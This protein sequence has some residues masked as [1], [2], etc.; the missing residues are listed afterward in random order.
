[1][2]PGLTIRKL[3][4]FRLHPQSATWGIVEYPG[5]FLERFQLHYPG[6]DRVDFPWNA[7]ADCSELILSHLV[8]Q[9]QRAGRSIAQFAKDQDWIFDALDPL[10]GQTFKSRWEALQG[11]QGALAAWQGREEEWERSALSAVFGRFSI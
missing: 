4:P 3:S 10:Y 6:Q 2:S 11:L 5:I 7:F 1:M 9:A 8:W